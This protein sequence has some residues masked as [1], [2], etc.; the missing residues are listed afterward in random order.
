MTKKKTVPGSRE[1]HY[2]YDYSTVVVTSTCTSYRRE[3]ETSANVLAIHSCDGSMIP[4]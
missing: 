2:N 1:Q 4:L 3:K